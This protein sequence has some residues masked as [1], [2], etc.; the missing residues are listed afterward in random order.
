MS[1][2]S[3]NKLGIKETQP[4]T[5]PTRKEFSDIFA[6][7]KVAFF[8]AGSGFWALD[9]SGDMKMLFTPNLH[10]PLKH[11]SNDDKLQKLI[12]NLEQNSEAYKEVNK[13]LY[14]DAKFNVYTHLRR[15]F[16]AKNKSL[17]GEVPFAITSPAPWQ[18]FKVK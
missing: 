17:L 7:N 18:V 1:F 8:N 9:P 5:K 4:I 16:V 3:V 15:F 13:Y 10:K 14:N 6:D 11:I 2:L 12:G